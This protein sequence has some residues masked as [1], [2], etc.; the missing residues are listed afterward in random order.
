MKY[1]LG[2]KNGK[3]LIGLSGIYKITN[4]ING[5]FYIGSSKDLSRRFNNWRSEYRIKR[6]HYYEWLYSN[7]L[8]DFQFELIEEV[9]PIKDLLWEREQYWVNNL[10]P[11]L[12]IC[13]EKV[14]GGHNFSTGVNHQDYGK[15]H[16]NRKPIIQ[17]DLNGNIIKEWEYLS[18]V[19]DFG[20]HK[21]DVRRVCKGK[22][23]TASG[24]KWKYKD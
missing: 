23:D 8:K 9:V 11:R 4:I 12:N 18:Q 14:N 21:G 19:Q 17:M 13:T 16:F 24:F 5:E 15:P 7:K 20:F 6:N 1:S 10:K 3:Y 2:E 22:R